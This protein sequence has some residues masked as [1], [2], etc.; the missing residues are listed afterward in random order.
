MGLGNQDHTKDAVSTNQ[1][2]INKV[3]CDYK[4]EK[5]SNSG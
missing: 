2:T 1:F 4:W 3:E 5:K